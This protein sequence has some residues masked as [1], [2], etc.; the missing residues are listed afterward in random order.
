ML[1]KDYERFFIS[2][3]VWAGLSANEKDAAIAGMIAGRLKKSCTSNDG[4][5]TVVKPTG[6]KKPGQRK[7]GRAERTKTIANKRCHTMKLI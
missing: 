7:R 4:N 2:Q 5:I 1:A 3:Q 6:S